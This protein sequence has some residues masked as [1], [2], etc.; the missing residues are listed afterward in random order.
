MEARFH[1]LGTT[2]KGVIT[3]VYG[4]FQMTHKQAFLDELQSLK[5]WV[6]MDHWII[7]GDFKLIRSLEEKKGGIS[8]LSSS[9][10]TFNK[11]TEVIQLADIQTTN[12]YFTFQNKH[13]RTRHIASLLD[14]FLVSETTLGGRA[15]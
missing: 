2:V 5:E 6:G 9:N 12:G 15:K 13:S 10:A 14:R 7:G 8:T 11:V 3:N 1:V 4:P